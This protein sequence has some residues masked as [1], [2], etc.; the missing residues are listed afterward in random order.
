MFRIILWS[1]ITVSNKIENKL[2]DKLTFLNM[3][4]CGMSFKALAMLS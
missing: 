2:M 1:S 3:R 4:V